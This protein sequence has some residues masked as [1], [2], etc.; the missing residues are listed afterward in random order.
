MKEAEETEDY[1]K[2]VTE[3]FTLACVLGIPY[4]LCQ[5]SAK[6]TKVF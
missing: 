2:K 4:C 6:L 3:A 5:T 1:F